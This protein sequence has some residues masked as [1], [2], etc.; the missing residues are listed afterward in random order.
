MQAGATRACRQQTCVGSKT[1]SVWLQHA[2]P[3]VI[4]AS[5]RAEPALLDSLQ[6][7]LADPTGFRQPRSFSVKLKKASLF[8]ARR[9]LAM[10]QSL[11][12][13]GMPSGADCLDSDATCLRG[14]L[15][16]CSLQA[17]LPTSASSSSLA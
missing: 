12:V 10:L 11:H 9:A 8:D 16:R 1:V 7:P 14:L 13:H 17:C 3:E 15:N 5:S 6:A 4:Y 2:D